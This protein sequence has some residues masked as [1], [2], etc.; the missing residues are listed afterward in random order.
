MKLKRIARVIK[1]ITEVGIGRLALAA[2][3]LGPGYAAAQD[4]PG[5][6][7]V[8]GNVTA[9]RKVANASANLGPGLSAD[10]N[11]GRHFALDA[12]F[13]WLPSTGFGGQTLIG[14]FGAKIGTRTK[15][16]GFFGKA[17]PGFLTIGNVFLASSIVV[18]QNPVATF[19]RLTERALDLGGV[20]EYYPARHW[21]LR[22]DMGDTLLFEER[23]PVFTGTFPGTPPVVLVTAAPARTT[24]HFQFSAGLNYRF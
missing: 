21:A 15:H 16:F 17:R 7:E 24:N 19:G 5:R 1:R 20:V 23:G 9:I 4:S 12:G 10:V 6:F 3:L 11:F 2:S 8:G 18:G 22:W 14:L 13:S